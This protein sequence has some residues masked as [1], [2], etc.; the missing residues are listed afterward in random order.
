MHVDLY[1]HHTHRVPFLATKYNIAPGRDAA[2]AKKEFVCKVI[3]NGRK[4]KCQPEFTR[5]SKEIVMMITD[6]HCAAV[7]LIREK[8]RKA[9]K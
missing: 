3:K 2:A 4:I 9:G 7:V 6:M 5:L 8:I 1:D